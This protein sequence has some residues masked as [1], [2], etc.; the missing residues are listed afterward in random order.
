MSDEEILP[1]KKAQSKKPLLINE[2]S[3]EESPPKL[4]RESS[5]PPSVVAPGTSKRSVLGAR[6]T[7][8][9]Q[10][11]LL[12]ELMGL[13]P[14]KPAKKP[15]IDS[16]KSK[17]SPSSSSDPKES[18]TS[19]KS[20]I[21]E[22]PSLLSQLMDSGSNKGKRKMDP[23]ENSESRDE[24]SKGNEDEEERKPSQPSSKKL[25]VMFNVFLCC[26]QHIILFFSKL[27]VVPNRFKTVT[28][29]KSV[30]VKI[31]DLKKIEISLKQT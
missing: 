29:L 24:E 14:C 31:D 16:T 23:V 6:V 27:R 8:Q 30:D 22:E 19:T 10:S 5:F 20:P 28:V 15:Y 1:K 3:E 26:L 9:S 25:K 12:D 13:G 21:N 7:V 11:D 4:A 2:D 18:T 17:K